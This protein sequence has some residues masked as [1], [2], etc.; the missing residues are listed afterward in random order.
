MSDSKLHIAIIGAGIAG[1]TFAI[2]LQHHPNITLQIYERATQLQEIGASI[3]LGPNGLR[4]LEKLGVTEALSDEIAFRNPSG[5]P[6]IY[7]HWKTNEV[8][9][10]DEHHGEVEERHRT[11]RFYRVRLQQALLSKL[12]EG[13]LNLGKG[14]ASIHESSEDGRLIV[15]FKDGSQAEADILL[16]ADGKIGRAHV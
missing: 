2:A 14:F 11:A 12:D 6:M 5:Y 9:S 10:V 13:I 3:A 7:R 1:L 4:T 15:T 16:G 8:V